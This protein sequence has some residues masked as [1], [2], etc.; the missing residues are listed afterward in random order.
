MSQ[1]IL[2]GEMKW[3]YTFLFSVPTV[4]QKQSFCEWLA[5]QVIWNQ[6][7]FSDQKTSLLKNK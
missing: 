6:K 3:S 5:I 1:K 4:I 2:K 7:Y